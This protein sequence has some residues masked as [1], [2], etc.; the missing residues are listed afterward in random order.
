MNILILDAYPKKSY[1]ISKDVNGGYGIAHNYGTTLFSKFLRLYVKYSI[2]FP[3]LYVVQVCGELLNCGHNVTYCD[4]GKS[5]K[6]LKSEK[7]YDLYIIAS[8]IVCHETEIEYLKELR[9]ENKLVLVIGP[10]A[11]SNPENYIKAG[12]IVIKG[13]PEMFFHKSKKKISDFKKL[14]KI[15][16]NFKSYEL[17]ELSF[18]GWKVIFK[19]YIPKVRFLGSGAT[20]NINASR[21]CPY[22]CFY[23]CVYPLQQ[24]RKLRFKSPKRLL[25]EMIYFN[26]TLNVSNFIFRDPVFSINREHTKEIC[27]AIIKSKYR[28]RLAIE[29]HLINIDENLAILLKKAGVKLIYVGVESQ[30][31]D[32][33]KNSK[34]ASEINS[35]QIQKIN[36][37]EKIGINV[38]AMYIIGMPTDSP[39]TFLKTIN[40]AIKINSTFAQFNV[41]TPYPGTPAYSEYKGIITKKK[42]EEFTQTQLVFKHK[43]FNDNDILKLLNFSIRSY[44]L[45]ISWIKKYIRN[46]IRERIWTLIK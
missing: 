19:N 4:T 43:N 5:I 20:I 38:K 18:P 40:Y 33:R 2:D 12:G 15:V 26:K 9:K 22:S 45:R 6:E 34:R 39:S 24:G 37:L 23:Y 7:K 17:D 10:F 42:Y 11:T 29:T 41:F 31:E 44:Y 16:Q 25:D 1:R 21:G 35:S 32:V 8:S 3:P 36:F 30:D 27:K 13:E 46:K 28:F 14:P